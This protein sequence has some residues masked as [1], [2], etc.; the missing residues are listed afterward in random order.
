MLLILKTRVGTVIV[1]RSGLK[2]DF[3][4]RLMRAVTMTQGVGT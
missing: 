4:D 1:P 3:G 2:S